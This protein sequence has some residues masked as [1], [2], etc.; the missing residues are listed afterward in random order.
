MRI[1]GAVRWYHHVPE[2][3]LMVAGGTTLGHLLAQ[4]GVDMAQGFVTVNGRP[5][6]V[7][8]LLADGDDIVVR[9]RGEAV[10]TLFN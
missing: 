9:G 1:T 4:L 7:G 3:R 8:Y 10:G 2:V 5:A 6:G